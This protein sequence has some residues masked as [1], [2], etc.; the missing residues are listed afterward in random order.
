MAPTTLEL[1]IQSLENLTG[2]SNI[3][4]NTQL[5]NDLALDS[6]EM[7]QLILQLNQILGTT[8]SSSDIV[9]EIFH[10]AASLARFID[11]KRLSL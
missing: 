10:N 9:P 11:T 1:I 8:L 7:V 5:K 2:E 4:A 3:D 6:L